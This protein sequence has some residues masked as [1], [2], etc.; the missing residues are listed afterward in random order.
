MLITTNT[1]HQ[2]QQLM[3][4]IANDIEKHAA[5]GELPLI[6]GILPN[7]SID[8]AILQRALFASVKNPMVASTKHLDVVEFLLK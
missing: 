7:S 1:H 5:D 8:P 4:K 6:E 3:S 2:Q